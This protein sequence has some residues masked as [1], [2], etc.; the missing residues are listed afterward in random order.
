MPYALREAIAALS[1][2]PLLIAMSVLAVGLSLFVFGL[3]GLTAFNVGAALDEIEERVEV[4]AYFRDSVTPEQVRLAEAEISTLPEVESIRFVSKT[5]ALATAVQELPEFREIFSG[6]DINPLPASLEIRLQPGYRTADAT[7]RLAQHVLTYPFVE[8]ASFGREW[9]GKIMALRQVAAGATLMIGGAFAAVAGII[10]AAAVRIAV[11]ARREEIEIMRL[12]G[13]TD[14]F[15]RAP[16]LIEGGFAGFVGALIA[17]GLTYVAFQY[18]DGALVG[19]VWLPAAWVF[20]AVVVGSVYGL[21]AS[22]VAVRT[23][24]RSS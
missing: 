4:V 24:L 23:Q 7:E 15:I 11:A 19:L 9:V 22:A 14:G 1:R 8:E 21:L 13:A 18:V 3:F 6:L 10:I 16:F 20:G 5:E 2:A 12:V 17:V